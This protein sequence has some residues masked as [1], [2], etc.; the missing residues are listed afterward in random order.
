MPAFPIQFYEVRTIGPALLPRQR[1][2]WLSTAS[3]QPGCAHPRPAPSAPAPTNHVPVG[4][5]ERVPLARGFGLIPP[6]LILQRQIP[7][8][9]RRDLLSVHLLFQLI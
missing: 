3:G 8:E 1:Q 2:R 5:P 4:C 6:E 7:T 9:V